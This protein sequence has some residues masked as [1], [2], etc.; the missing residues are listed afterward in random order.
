M[1]TITATT[2]FKMPLYD[3][4]F[5]LSASSKTLTEGFPAAKSPFFLI[6]KAWVLCVLKNCINPILQPR[7][8]VMDYCGFFFNFFKK[9]HFACQECSIE[10]RKNNLV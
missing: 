8:P 1:R 10:G 6:L 4:S 5:P 3:I 2:A 9:C 7:S